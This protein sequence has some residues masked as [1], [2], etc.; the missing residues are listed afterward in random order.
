MNKHY[1]TVG[2]RR[3][4]AAPLAGTRRFRCAGPGRGEGGPI[5]APGRGEGGLGTAVKEGG[6]LPLTREGSW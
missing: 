5:A 4:E 6:R 1:D 3:R 2:W